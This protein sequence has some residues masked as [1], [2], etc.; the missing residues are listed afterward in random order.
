MSTSDNLGINLH[1][2]YA[3]SGIKIYSLSK[4]LYTVLANME[5]LNRIHIALHNAGMANRIL[6]KPQQI[7]CF[8]YICNGYDVI[9]VLPTG[10]GKS[11]LFQL[12]PDILPTKTTISIVIVLCPLS[13]IIEDQLHSLKI[14]S[15]NAGVLPSRYEIENCETLFNNK[16]DMAADIHL[17]DDIVNGLTSIVFAHPED[18]L[19]DVGRKLMKSDVYQKNVVACVIDEGH[20]VEMW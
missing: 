5:I 3:D 20:C 10:F 11:V 9:A 6:N 1:N 19:S 14:M 2:S 8:D 15:I 17:L 16:E 12:L 7:Q 18:L 13:S 4:E